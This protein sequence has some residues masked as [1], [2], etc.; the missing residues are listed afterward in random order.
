MEVSQE[1]R[2]IILKTCISLTKLSQRCS[3]LQ[4]TL[5]RGLRAHVLPSLRLSCHVQAVPS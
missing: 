2:T 3:G 4:L 1:Q 5:F